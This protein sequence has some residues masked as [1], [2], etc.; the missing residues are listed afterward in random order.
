MH[1]SWSFEGH[2]AIEIN[3]LRFSFDNRV[4]R[5]ENYVALCP[6]SAVFERTFC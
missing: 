1:K 2:I 4:A 5:G 3:K 6:K